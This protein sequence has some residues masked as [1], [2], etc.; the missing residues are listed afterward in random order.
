MVLTGMKES[1]MNS[2]GSTTAID[3][4]AVS[5]AINNTKAYRVNKNVW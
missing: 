2:V 5:A 4:L 3:S 1:G